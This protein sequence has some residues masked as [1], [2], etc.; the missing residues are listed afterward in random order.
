MA[1]AKQQWFKNCVTEW[2]LFSNNSVGSKGFECVGDFI[3]SAKRG[4]LW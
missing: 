3:I 1:L 2:L 4:N